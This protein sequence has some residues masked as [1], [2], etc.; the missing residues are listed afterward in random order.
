MTLT[1]QEAL[2]FVF[3][4]VDYERHAR[5]TYNAA[6]LDLSRVSRLLA[7]LG[8][9]HRAFCAVHIAGTKGKGS[10]AAM[11]E[12]V[13][14]IAGFRTGLY[15]SP[16]LHTFRERIRVNGLL[17]CREELVSLVERCQTA[18]ESVEG[19]TTFEVITALGFLQFAEQ[20]V[21]W[22]VVETGLGGRLD[23]TNVIS[24]QVT[25]ITT[26]SYDHTYLLG[27]TLALIAA[28]KAGIIKQG[29][30][31]VCAPQ[32]P[33]ALHV[34]EDVC[35]D[36]GAEMALVG[37]D[38]HWEKLASDLSG[39]WLRV[40]ESTDR[41]V[42]SDWK[43]LHIPLLG[44]HQLL[45]STMAVALIKTL[46]RRGVDIPPDSVRQGLSAVR[47][48]GRLEIL[49]R[50][51]FVL[52]DGAHNAD[53]ISKLTVALVDKFPHDRLLVIFGASEDKDIQA[54]LEALVPASDVLI[55]TRARHPRAAN[56]QDLARQ[57]ASLLRPGQVV[58]VSHSVAGA[59]EQ[60]LD[61]A[62]PGD[63]ICGTGSLFVAAE[64]RES[65]A[66]LLPSD[67]WVHEAEPV[68]ATH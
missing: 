2:D 16:H 31:L 39:Q 28:E 33:D 36:R 34:I 44:D 21:E 47:W 50:R 45:N 52:A 4:F 59:V 63:L 56:P 48:P 35:R 67:D 32:P 18:I 41:G 54:M 5:F 42:L 3:G 53:S 14:R 22:A 43:N 51:P 8:D 58:T 40:W 38:W 20:N 11:T 15:T 46:R 57:T 7:L 26:L 1:Y 12:S 64:V 49:R 24:P 10:A 66:S 23:A 17:L 19:I 9:P 60:A 25:A 68:L 65:Q 30:P 62:Q 55:T 6:T 13:L 37:R 27:D 61:W 29:V